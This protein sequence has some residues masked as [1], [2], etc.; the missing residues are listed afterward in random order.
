ME[1]LGAELF[2]GD[3]CPQVSGAPMQQVDGGF[4]AYIAL[5]NLNE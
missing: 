5:L 3:G 4:M 2:N 1:Q